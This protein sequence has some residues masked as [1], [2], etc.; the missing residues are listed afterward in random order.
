MEKVR[1]F[2]TIMTTVG[3]YMPLHVFLTRQGSKSEKT[4][5]HVSAF[6]RQLYM[7]AYLVSVGLLIA[8]DIFVHRGGRN[9]KLYILHIFLLKVL[10]HT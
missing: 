9:K 5:D 3:Q 1:I 6:G 7:A 2:L 10:Y 4:F 8:S